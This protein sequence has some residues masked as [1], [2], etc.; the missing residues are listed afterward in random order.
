LVPKLEETLVGDV[1]INVEPDRFNLGVEGVAEGI[2]GAVVVEE[3]GVGVGA[4]V[5]D[6]VI[7]VVVG[8]GDVEV[9]EV[10]VLV[11]VDEVGG[12]GDR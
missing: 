8:V 3:E 10:E 5:V 7:V 11:V 9:V 6:D 4:G 12:G 1:N 2:V